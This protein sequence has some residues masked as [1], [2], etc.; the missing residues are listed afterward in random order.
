MVERN[1]KYT[2][3]SLYRIVCYKS[4]G[5]LQMKRDYIE[6]YGYFDLEYL[7]EYEKLECFEFFVLLKLLETDEIHIDEYIKKS[8]EE[9]KNNPLLWSRK[10]NF[11][12]FKRDQYNH[13]IKNINKNKTIFIFKKL[14]L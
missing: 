1:K 4:I 12:A 9:R 14:K 13:I 2:K 8:L 3:L 10:R 6:Q 5:I 7:C 11:W